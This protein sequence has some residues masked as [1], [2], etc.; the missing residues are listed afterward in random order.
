MMMDWQTIVVALVVLCAVL[1][2]ANRA[3]RRLR[4]FVTTKRGA[5]VCGSSC[6]CGDDGAPVIKHNLSQRMKARE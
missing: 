4:S 5:S 2:V 3:W 6:G 1:Y